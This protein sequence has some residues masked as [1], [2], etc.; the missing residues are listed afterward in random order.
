VEFI[1]MLTRDDRT[2]ADAH[3]LV[4][5]FA[6][7]GV[8]HIG[9]KDVGVPLAELAPLAAHISARGATSY[10]E[11]V[12]VS[13]EDEQRSVRA[14]LD[15]GVDNVL[16]GTRVAKATEILAG[17]AIRYWPFL[18]DV[19]GHPSQ[20]HG[21]IESIV[22]QAKRWSELDGVHGFDLL[23]YRYSGDAIALARAVFAAVEMPVI[24]AG[25][26]DSTERISSLGEAGAYGFTIGTALLDRSLKIDAAS[27]SLADLARAVLVTTR[28]SS[29]AR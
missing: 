15:L 10:L 4:D 22:D 14:A 17:S 5:L 3:S 8:R 27:S 1:L 25:S 28:I 2:V 12:S 18:G 24:A 19:R 23:A 11:V 29:R 9:F 6:D 20:L 7:A 21:S 13:A 16:G 26:V